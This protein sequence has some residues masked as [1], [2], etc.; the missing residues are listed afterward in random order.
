M[1]VNRVPVRGQVL[2]AGLGTSGVVAKAGRRI[3]RVLVLDIIAEDETER[4]LDERG[5]LSTTE[6]S[7]AGIPDIGACRRT[8]DLE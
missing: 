2:K 3:D 7:E 5:I 8:E 1:L 6:A 4:S